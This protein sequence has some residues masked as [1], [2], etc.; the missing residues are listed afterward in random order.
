MYDG[1]DVLTPGRWDDADGGRTVHL[2][3]ECRDLLRDVVDSV[4][5]RL[6]EPPLPE[7][8]W[9]QALRWLDDRCGGR[10]A[11][12]RLD[13]EPLTSPVALPPVAAS[14]EVADLEAVGQPLILTAAT[15][16]RLIEVR[17][18]AVRLRADAQRSEAGPDNQP[19]RSSN[20]ERAVPLLAP[21][22]TFDV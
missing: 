5:A 18:R 9:L 16:A 2:C 22:R 8:D 3:H 13:T 6:I 4:Q 21:E 12:L 20:A 1:R 10:E 11:V 15:R 17:D 19:A 7:P 14:G